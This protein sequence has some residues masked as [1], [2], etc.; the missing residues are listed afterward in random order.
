MDHDDYPAGFIRGILNDVKTVAIVGASSNEVR[1]SYFVTKYLIGKGDEVFPVNPSKAGQP[2]LGR[3][4]YASL[5]DIPV[6]LGMV[7]IFRNSHAAG[8]IVDEALT[9][10]PLPE[11][12]WMQLTVRNDQAARRAEAKGLRVVMNRCPKIEYGKLSGEWG[13]VGGNSG[14]I[15]SKKQ[16]LHP[17]GKLQSLGI[18]PR[19]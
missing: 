18:S 13:W 12:I 8:A 11:V 5:G 14:R 15:S 3:T 16:R 7:D 2:V 9:L 1:P 6:P 19:K 10:D 4:F 17:S